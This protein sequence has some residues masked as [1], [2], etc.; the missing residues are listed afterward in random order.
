MFCRMFALPAGAV[1]IVLNVDVP[2]Q[3]QTA[4]FQAAGAALAALCQA[5]P[6]PGADACPGRTRHLPGR[7]PG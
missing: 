1:P 6:G 2:H 5:S 7:P 4:G 3:A